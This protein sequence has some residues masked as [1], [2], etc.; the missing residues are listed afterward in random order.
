WIDPDDVR[1]GDPFEV[2]CDMTTDGGGWTYIAT[3]TNA[4]DGVDQGNWLETSPNPNNWEGTGAFGP[5]DPT[6]NTD[7][8]SAGFH[9]IQA[10]ALMV[11]HRNLFL[12]RTS[13]TCLPNRSL[14]DHFTSLSWSCGGSVSLGGGTTCANPC[15]IVQSTVR[16]GDTAMMSNA[17][18]GSLFFKAGESDGVQD[19][20]KDRAYLSTSY[21]NNVDYPTGLGAFCSGFSCGPRTGE[22]DVNDRSD[23]IVPTSGS[24]FYGLWVR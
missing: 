14:S 1:A 6:S 3:I 7:F 19:T 2:V 4:G 12:L 21:R 24:E 23:A 10:S 22:A 11:R 15:E 5:R 18:R 16:A 20:N 8:R 9:R 17:Q 13:N